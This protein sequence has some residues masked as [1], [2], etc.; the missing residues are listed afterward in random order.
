MQTSFCEIV[1]YLNKQ[2]FSHKLP[3]RKKKEIVSPQFI[4]HHKGE[5]A[6]LVGRRWGKLEKR[7]WI[8]GSMRRDADC[9]TEMGEARS[10]E[11]ERGGEGESSQTKHPAKR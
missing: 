6:N 7:N 9:E 3:E 4:S 2:P 8:K 1:F 10:E 11:R 5:Y